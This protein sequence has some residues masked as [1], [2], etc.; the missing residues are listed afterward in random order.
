M[1]VTI[2]LVHSAPLTSSENNTPISFGKVIFVLL[3]SSIGLD[4]R[5]RSVQWT[6]QNSGC[7]CCSWVAILPSTCKLGL[8][9]ASL[10][11]TLSGN[12]ASLSAER[13]DSI[14]CYEVQSSYIHWKEGCLRTNQTWGNTEPSRGSFLKSSWEH[15]IPSHIWSQLLCNP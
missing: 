7:P 5:S 3:S 13:R 2:S 10:L 8:S 1:W 6:Y 15:L 9:S 11:L 4:I 12:I 14:K